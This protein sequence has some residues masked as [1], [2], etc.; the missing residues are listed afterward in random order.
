MLCVF[1]F[2]LFV[3]KTRITRGIYVFFSRACYQNLE[4]V[5][6]LNRVHVPVDMQPGQRR[7]A[8]SLADGSASSLADGTAACAEGAPDFFSPYLFF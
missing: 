4:R 3:L 8:T 6:S 1:L 2:A 5:S 7:G